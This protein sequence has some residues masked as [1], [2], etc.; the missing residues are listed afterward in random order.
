MYLLLALTCRALTSF[1]TFSQVEEDYHKAD[2]AL[3]VEAR[4]GTE[5]V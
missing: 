3:V 1:F 5:T 2:V 4:A